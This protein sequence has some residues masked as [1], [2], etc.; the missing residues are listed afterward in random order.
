MRGVLRAGDDEIADAAAL[1]FGRHHEAPV[2]RV[3]YGQPLLGQ[4]SAARWACR[5]VRLHVYV[6]FLDILANL[7]IMDK[8]EI[9][10]MQVT[11]VGLAGLAT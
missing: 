5:M 6:L 3:L 9:F 10:D 11:K 2:P 7:A 8:L 1:N 4:P